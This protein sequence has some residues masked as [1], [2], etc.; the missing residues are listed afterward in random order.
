LQ[1]NI[2]FVK[3]KNAA[4]LMSERKVPFEVFFNFLGFGS[5]IA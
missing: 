4:P 3:E 2:G 5:D 1:E